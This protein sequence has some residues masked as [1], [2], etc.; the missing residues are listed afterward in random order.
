MKILA[1]TS[2]KYPVQKAKAAYN[3]LED[4]ID[5]VDSKHAAHFTDNEWKTL[6]KALDI[7][8]EYVYDVT[9]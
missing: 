3:S 6:A 4:L 1:N 5:E 2:E 7:L 9:H 8:K